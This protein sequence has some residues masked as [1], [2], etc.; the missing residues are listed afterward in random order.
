MRLSSWMS[1]S[2]VAPVSSRPKTRFSVRTL[3]REHELFSVQDASPAGD[4]VIIINDTSHMSEDKQERGQRLLER[5]FS[6]H[7]SPRAVRAGTTIKQTLITESGDKITY[8]AFVHGHRD[9]LLYPVL[10]RQQ[11]IFDNDNLLSARPKDNVVRIT[12]YDE[13]LTTFCCIVWVMGKDAEAPQGTLRS[14]LHRFREFSLLITYSFWPIRPPDFGS[15]LNVTTS[16]KR[17]NTEDPVFTH[18]DLE[19]IPAEEFD[20]HNL[21]LLTQLRD[22]FVSG[23][24]YRY[25]MDLS[26]LLKLNTVNGI[27]YWLKD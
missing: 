2:E 27:R 19:A 17:V 10:V 15:T 7:P 8:A 20:F 23:M 21:E 24:V 18:P 4:L 22:M 12:E 3:G 1:E 25:G 9:K 11:W 26:S 14:S 5:R 13:R 6:V 16:K